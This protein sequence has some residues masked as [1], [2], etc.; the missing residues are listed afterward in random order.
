MWY[1]QAAICKKKSY[2][3]AIL[4]HVLANVTREGGL[5]KKMA[6]CDIGDGVEKCHFTS[7]VLFEWLFT[8]IIT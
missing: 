7:D 5:E 3:H 6:K 4:C 2:F 1:D 8:E